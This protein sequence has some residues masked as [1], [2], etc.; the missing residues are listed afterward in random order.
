MKGLMK[1]LWIIIDGPLFI[2]YVRSK[3][4]CFFENLSIKGFTFFALHSVDKNLNKERILGL[5]LV[6]VRFLETIEGE[7]KQL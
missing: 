4:C 7:V 6:K 5:S 1:E 2:F 3:I